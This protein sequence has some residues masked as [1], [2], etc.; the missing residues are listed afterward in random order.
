M[1]VLVTFTNIENNLLSG[2]NLKV[3]PIVSYIKLHL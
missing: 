3:S 1:I 2:G